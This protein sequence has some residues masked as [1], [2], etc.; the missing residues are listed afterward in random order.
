MYVGPYIVAGLFVCVG[1]RTALF[2]NGSL[3]G[4]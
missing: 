2:V 1:M 4:I 3:L